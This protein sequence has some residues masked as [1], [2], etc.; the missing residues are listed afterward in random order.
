MLK[1]IVTNFVI[2]SILATGYAANVVDGGQPITGKHDGRN[3]NKLG[4]AYANTIAANAKQSNLIDNDAETAIDTFNPK[5]TKS[6]SYFGVLWPR[7]IVS[8]ITELSIVM[9]IFKD[10]GWFGKNNFLPTNKVLSIDEAISKNS[11]PIVQITNDL[12][13]S[14]KTVKTK[15][16]YLTRVKNHQIKEIP[17]FIDSITFEVQE[18]ISDINGIRIIGSEGGMTLQTKMVL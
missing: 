15:S 18:P 7:H 14:W 17:T 16:N 9:K 2:S 4:T 10:G 12:G 6:Y 8:E 13:K 3:L 11:Q 5:C 1:T